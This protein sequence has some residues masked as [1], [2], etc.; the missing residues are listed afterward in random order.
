VAGPQRARAP[1]RGLLVVP[2][3]RVREPAGLSVQ[4]GLCA[5]VLPFFPF[6]GGRMVKVE[7][8]IGD[9]AYVDLERQRMRPWHAMSAGLAASSSWPDRSRR[10]HRAAHLGRR[11]P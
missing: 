8:A 4:V 11:G 2:G 1:R 5:S 9:D 6:E 7:V 3:D 10:V